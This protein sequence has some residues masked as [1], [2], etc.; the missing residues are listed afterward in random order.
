MDNLENLPKEEYNKIPVYYCKSCGS[1]K[2]MIGPQNIL[3]DFCDDCGSTDIG[4]A[5]IESWQ[6]LQKTKFK[7]KYRE[8]P[9]HEYDPFKGY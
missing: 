7:P 2:V 3:S 8:R 4:K 5:S 9:V 1:L 6:E